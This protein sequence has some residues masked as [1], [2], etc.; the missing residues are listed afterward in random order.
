MASSD[1]IEKLRGKLVS[2]SLQWEADGWQDRT[3]NGRTQSYQK[4]YA[5]V[6]TI[7]FHLSATSLLLFSLRVF[8][9]VLIDGN[10]YNCRS[11]STVHELQS[12]PNPMANQ[13]IFKFKSET[14]FSRVCPPP[15]FKWCERQLQFSARHVRATR[16]GVGEGGGGAGE[17]VVRTAY[18]RVGDWK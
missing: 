2:L 15:L 8:N 1:C 11:R 12:N 16:G 13:I 3:L 14:L 6:A 10:V 4:Y 17:D 5:S 9:D 18:V 7:R